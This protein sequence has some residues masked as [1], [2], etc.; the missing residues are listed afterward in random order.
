MPVLREFLEEG[1][2]PE[3]LDILAEL[4]KARIDV[5]V[6]LPAGDV[7][8]RQLPDGDLPEL[9]PDVFVARLSGWFTAYLRLP[10]PPMERPHMKLSSR[11]AE[12]GSQP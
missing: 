11:F 12:A 8:T 3:R 2:V 9:A 5:L 4:E 1:L 7:E 10:S 6:L